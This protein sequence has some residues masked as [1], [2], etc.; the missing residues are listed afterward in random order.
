MSHKVAAPPMA[1]FPG[2]STVFVDLNSTSLMEDG[3]I[4]NPY[5]TIQA[6]LDATPEPGSGQNFNWAIG[7]VPGIYDENLVLPAKGNVTLAPVG[8][9][10]IYLGVPL[11]TPRSMTWAPVFQAEG[12][13]RVSLIS[14][15]IS[16]NFTLTSTE[17][18]VSSEVV[19]T[20]CT[21]RGSILTGFILDP[22]MV[23][24]F[25][26]QC[27]VDGSVSV[28]ATVRGDR[29]DLSGNLTCFRMGAVSQ[30]TCND[31]TVTDTLVALF[32]C[33]CQ[34]ATFA[35]G[36]RIRDVRVQ[37]ELV[38]TDSVTPYEIR[39]T[40]VDGYTSLADCNL[41]EGVDI[42]GPLNL[43]GTTTPNIYT[44]RFTGLVTCTMVPFNLAHASAFWGGI[45]LAHIPTRGFFG[46]HIEGFFNGPPGSYLV[47]A[48]SSADSSP[49]LVPPT[50]ETVVTVGGPPSGT[51]GGGLFGYYP[52]P[53][54]SAAPG[55]DT[56]AMHLLTASVTTGTIAPFGS[57]DVNLS[58]GGNQILI[59][60][61]YIR[62]AVTSL[63][64]SVRVAS[65][66]KDD[67]TTL[68]ANLFGSYMGWNISDGAWHLGPGI[69]TG[70]APVFNAAPYRDEDGTNEVH[71]RVVNTDYTY[72]GVFEIRLAYL[73]IPVTL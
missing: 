4:L 56:T 24:L 7:V 11:G 12:E 26:T 16:G 41:L 36:G 70:G 68:G 6:A 39:D 34:N 40:Q 2:G 54:V 30:L 32:D 19:L 69:E 3:S 62:R 21:V 51:A 5:K 45:T 33:T 9:G 66:T 20:Q 35:F 73:L 28:E 29:N 61:F 48:T 57:E 1:P 17:S 64:E 22:T 52:D 15:V 43:I 10:T 60:G 47:D 37:G 42:G 14:F 27:V 65:Y 44:S 50:S 55:L 8:S 18:T 13:H 67:F 25:L 72:T 63:V 58:V 59:V 49:T 71:F 46:C 38:I 23:T 53:Y 31:I